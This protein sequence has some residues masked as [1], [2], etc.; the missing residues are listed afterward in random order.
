MK[1]SIVTGRERNARISISRAELANDKV[2]PVRGIIL[3]AY[4]LSLLCANH[5][6]T[7]GSE[8]FQRWS[9]DRADKLGAFEGS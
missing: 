3:E 7:G 4:E 1:S 5:A 2:D 9:F 6:L 8:R